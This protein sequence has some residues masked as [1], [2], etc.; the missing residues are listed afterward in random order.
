MAAKLNSPNMYVYAD[1]I[2]LVREERMRFSVM[3]ACKISLSHSLRGKFGS[4][5]ANPALKWFF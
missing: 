2:G 5:L 1:I 3:L 4:T